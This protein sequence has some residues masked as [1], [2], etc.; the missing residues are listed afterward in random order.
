MCKNLTL[1]ISVVLVL[2][3]A[4]SAQADPYTWTNDGD[5]N[6]WCERFNWDPNTSV[7]GPGD[8]AVIRNP[9]R[10]PVVDCD[11]DVAIIDGPSNGQVMD[12]IS[13]TVSTTGNWDLDDGSSTINI[14]G[15]PV[16]DIG[17]G[18]IQKNGTVTLNISGNPTIT[19]G[20]S[21]KFADDGGDWC[22][23]NMSGGSLTVVGRL[24]WEDHGGGVLNMSGGATIECG[25]FNYSG[26]GDDPW[27]LNLNG[28]TM[29]VAG[30]FRAPEK[31]EG[32]VNVFINLDAGTLECGSFDHEGNEYAM[33]INEGMFIIDGDERV[34]MNADVTAGYI[35]AFNDTIGVLVTYDGVSNKTIVKAD[36]AQVK[37]WDPS[38]DNYA[39]N[40][41]PGVQLSWQAGE[42]AVDHNVYFGPSISDVNESADP[43]LDHY[44]STQWTPPGLE[45]G[46]TY[47]WRVDEVDDACDASPWVGDI[48]EFTTNDGN[49]SDPY[50]EN[51][52]TVVPA[53]AKLH[54]TPGCTADSHD[55]YFGTDYNDVRDA[56]NLWPV[57]VSVYKGNQAVGANEYD[58]CD[59]DYLTWYYWRIDEVADGTI[60][61]G[62][63]LSFRSISAVVDPN[64]ILWYKLD[65]SHGLVVSDSSGYEHHGN[66]H[67]IEDQWEPNN[68]HF[69]GCLDFDADE[70]VAVP[71]DTLETI[72]KEITVS[73]WVKGDDDHAD[74]EGKVFDT[75]TGDY[76][77]RVRIP[78][79]DGDLLWRA[80][81]DSNDSLVWY[82][83]SPL[84]WAEDW[85]FFAFVKDENAGT[86]K[87]YF[88]GFEAESKTGT[89]NSLTNVKGTAFRIGADNT[90]TSDYT[91]KL[92]DF[93][94]YDCALSATKI[95]GLFRGGDLGIAW[96]PSP[97]NGEVDVLCDVVLEWKPGD[98]AS[99]H[100]VYLGT[101][102][103]DINDVNT[104]N[105]AGYPNVDYNNVDVN[106]YAPP[107]L[108]EFDTT[109][110][111]RIDEI[112]DANNDRW[113]GDIWKFTVANYIVI[114]DM[115]D[116][117]PLGG[118]HDIFTG[119][120]DGSTNWT[121]S[122]L[123]LQTVAP[124]H[125]EQS[126]K[127]VY[128]NTFNWGPGYY[129][130][131]ES[132]NLDPNDWSVFDLRILSLWFHG[133]AG[134]DANATEQMYVGLEDH[135]GNYAD[136]RYGDGEGE[137]MDDIRVEEWQEWTMALADFTGVN[138]AKLEKLFI[139]FGTR[140]GLVPGGGGLTHWVH[141]DDIRLYPAYCVPEKGP[142]AD[143][144]NNCIVDFADIEIMA[145]AWLE[146]DVNLGE[147]VK[148][149]ANGLVGWWKLDDGDG[150]IA[151]DYAG[152]DN[153]GVIETI[154]VDVWWVAGRP[155]PNGTPDGNALEF[156]GGRVLVPDACEL[157]PKH[158][159]T[160]CAWVKFPEAQD[161]SA[162][163]VCK[164][165][166]NKETFGLEVNEDD[167]FTFQVRDG[168]APNADEYPRYAVDSNELD[169]GEW[170]HLA[171]TFDGNSVKCYVNGQLEGTNNDANA[172]VILSQDTND[173]AIGNRSDDD[174]REFIGTIDDVRVY[175]Y[176]LSLEEVKYIATDGTKIFSV[177]SVA[178][179]YNKE[180]LGERVVNIRDFAELAKDW[181][182][183]KLWP[184]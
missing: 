110:Y 56:N 144:S 35:T 104:S 36:Y 157:R 128:D 14:T 86:M 114:D 143:L 83:A 61:K 80:G 8:T 146:T 42:Y 32:P 75:G 31:S 20:G 68:G 13:G 147:V 126:M 55:V 1:L 24:A 165:A 162:R 41:C 71:G 117:T 134:N 49:A 76:K 84:A 138:T 100:D 67:A 103:D 19:I 69:D 16:I 154:D 82:Q 102:W 166:D 119:W 174:D 133:K 10:G 94:I 113:K 17:G 6:S 98:Y 47:Y 27:T 156:D 87:I 115:E 88:D 15:T 66:G 89:I 142:K 118:G 26:D 11:V 109:Y 2:G 127:Y 169:H 116:Y 95:A 135:D 57:D 50:P 78:T 7:P 97:Y 129:S 111:W 92:D 167:I 177:Q 149:D 139:G 18:I 101:N 81:N 132:K 173:L 54:L 182:E 23:I 46:T 158:Q 153:N 159:V 3:L 130:E 106:S 4:C 93:R 9:H 34:A 28:G 79:D 171:G 40:E 33:D 151:T 91:G 161:H 60:Y 53:D 107:S 72:N 64:L 137:D 150:N 90:Q 152:Y 141:F 22:T 181:L 136:V 122:Y 131:I 121:G 164:G 63:V 178:N 96:A 112:N 108:L 180:D 5:G 145:D 170:I 124:V 58:P 140:G 168:N 43:C 44:G 38:P 12:V 52:E 148:P 74:E 163:V 99:S 48:W 155:L 120:L 85:H 176:A 123:F 77:M 51:K 179:L 105:Y 125:G 160:T 184:E 37:A 30:R 70:H 29:T 59:F 65:E 175:N 62:K 183:K 21:T 39:Q 45:L 25:E 73:V 172:V